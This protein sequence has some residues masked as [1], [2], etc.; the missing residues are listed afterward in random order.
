MQTSVSLPPVVAG[1]AKS[2]SFTFTRAGQ[3]W[4]GVTVASKLR[5]HSPVETVVFTFGPIVVITAD[6][7]TVTL[8]MTGVDTAAIGVSQVFGDIVIEIS[9]TFGPY[10]PV[11]FNF[12]IT[13]RITS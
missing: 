7:F 4:T 1:D 12:A 2:I 5:T 11:Q 13:P 8:P 10:T 3:D 6:S 9:P